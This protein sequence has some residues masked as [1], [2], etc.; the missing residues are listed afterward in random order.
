MSVTHEQPPALEIPDRIAR[1][2]L[3]QFTETGIRRTSIEDVA[4]RAGLSRVTIYRHVGGKDRLLE[5]VIANETRRAMDELDEVLEDHPE[6]GAALEQGFA[7]LVRLVREHPLFNRLLHTE[8]ELVLPALTIDGGPILSLYRSLIA[9]RF[10]KMKQRGEIAPPDVDWA[11]ETFARLGLSLVLTPEGVIG[12]DDP[13][14]IAA[15]ARQ[16][17][18]PILRP[19]AV[20]AG[21]TGKPSG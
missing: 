15:F 3:E 14:A 17:L 18:L 4:R 6:A 16:T 10:E 12:A 11:A 9:E 21:E 13:E 20:S 5:L 8:P 19:S 7:T 1:A 2:A